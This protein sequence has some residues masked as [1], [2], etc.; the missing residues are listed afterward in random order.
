MQ[1]LQGM[2]ADPF[3]GAVRGH[4]VVALYNNQNLWP[5][6]GYPGSSYQDGG[7]IHRGFDDIDWLPEA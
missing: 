6:F 2:A 5:Q 4:T 1:V 7:Y 3:F